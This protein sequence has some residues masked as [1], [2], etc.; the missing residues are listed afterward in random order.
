MLLVNNEILE[1]YFVNT[2]SIT[3]DIIKSLRFPLVCTVHLL[4]IPQ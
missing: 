2:D 1:L 3:P 4:V